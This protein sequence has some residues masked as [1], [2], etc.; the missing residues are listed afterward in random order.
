MMPSPAARARA[1]NSGSTYLNVNSDMAGMFER[2]MRMLAPDGEMSSVETLSPSVMRTVASN[3][4]GTGLPTGIG[5]ML[6]PLTTSPWPSGPTRHT[7]D[8][9]KAAGRRTGGSAP[10]DRGSVMTP[11]SAEAAATTEEHK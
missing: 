7:S 1:A 10:S 3:V 2:K 4:S 5:L 11:V 8:A 6:G 9:A